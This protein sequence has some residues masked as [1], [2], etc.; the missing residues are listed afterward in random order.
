MFKFRAV[1]GQLCSTNFQAASGC[2]HAEIQDIHADRIACVHSSADRLQVENGCEQLA[3]AAS[4]A[5]AA[6]AR[7]SSSHFTAMVASLSCVTPRGSSDT[8]LHQFSF[9][10]R[11]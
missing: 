3:A 11:Q 10:G 7:S 4:S 9:S 1:A 5:L 2:H 6:S 8:Q